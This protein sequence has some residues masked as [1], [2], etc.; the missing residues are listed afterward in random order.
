MP[1]DV[2]EVQRLVRGKGVSIFCASCSKYQEGRARGLPGHRCTS[3]SIP[4]CGSPL[5]GSAF[6]DYDGPITETDRWCFMCG[7]P[8]TVGIS[9][10]RHQKVF[11]L[12]ET[13]VAKASGIIPTGET[14]PPVVL[15]HR[16]GVE[17]LGAAIVRPSPLVREMLATQE[18]WDHEAK[19]RGMS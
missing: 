17:L 18:E 19:K 12:C 2:I 15:M 3:V 8:A 1:L 14:A 4:A 7:E 16:Q 9:T 10:P 5:A 13:H 6:P 11:G